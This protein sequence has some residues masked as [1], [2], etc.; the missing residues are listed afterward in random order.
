M[1]LQVGVRECDDE[2]AYFV[3]TPASCKDTFRVAWIATLSRDHNVAEQLGGKPC[4]L[5]QDA[6]L[7]RRP[8]PRSARAPPDPHIRMRFTP[9][10]IAPARQQ[11]PRKRGPPHRPTHWPS[12]RPSAANTPG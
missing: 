5:K 6:S 4:H 2:G 7:W 12:T 9:C 1:A 10:S 11:R 3:D 8:L